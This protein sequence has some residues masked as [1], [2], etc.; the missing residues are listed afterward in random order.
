MEDPSMSTFFDLLDH[1]TPSQPMGAA[2]FNALAQRLLNESALIIGGVAHQ[3]VEIECY[4]H[5]SEHCDP[6]AHCD[7]MQEQSRRWYFHRVGGSYRGGSF[8]GLDISFGTSQGDFGGIL[9]RT[10][11]DP[12][13]K[14][15]NGCSLCVDHMLTTTGHD[16]VA[17][18]DR[19]VHGR[20]VADTES[21]LHLRAL[22]VPRQD[23]VIATARVGLTLKR[24]HANP[25]M[26][27]YI[28]RRYRFLTDPTIKKGKVHT[29]IA[30]HQQGMG[31]ETLSVHT[32]S[33]RKSIARYIEA[34]REGLSECGFERYHGLALKTQDL[35]RLHGT[36][37]MHFG[38][39]PKE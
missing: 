23:T 12:R 6:F 13:G 30:L 32:R 3:L 15:I 27:R 18:L 28:M 2:W 34:Y 31:V 39:A 7:P 29:I 4:Y 22:D 5:G 21:I 20:D 25:E 10:L 26:P 38:S 24:A 37:I 19:A 1:P 8:K 33:P 11:T 35:C 17:S 16:H 9:I 14:H 36:W